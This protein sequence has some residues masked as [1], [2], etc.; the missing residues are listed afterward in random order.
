ME[1]NEVIVMIDANSSSDDTTIIQF[2]DTHGLF[3]LMINYLPDWQ[4]PT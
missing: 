1:G 4:P 2:L 3:D